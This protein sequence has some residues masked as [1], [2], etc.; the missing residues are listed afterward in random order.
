VPV[1]GN[2]VEYVPGGDLRAIAR[3]AGFH[4]DPP[5][6][7]PPEVLF[8]KWDW[9]LE[10]C[11]RY[12]RQVPEGGL[13]F[14]PP[15]RPRTLRNLA[16]HALSIARSFLRAYDEGVP[17]SWRGIMDLAPDDIQTKEELAA[18]GEESRRMLAEWWRD[19]GSQD[20]LDRVIETYQG[21]QT[22]LEAFERQTWHTAQHT[23][24][25]MMFLT[26]LDT[27]PDR[28]LT[29]D[30]LAGLPMPKGWWD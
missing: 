15:D 17:E 27:E 23:R 28:P 11:V 9:I 12:V 22:L 3:I 26:W 6:I 24:Q 20:P 1:V 29:D 13:E 2:G 8:Q 7:L 4:Y 18:Y 19:A 30:D 21:A 16:F 14:E 10:S 5:E 25:V